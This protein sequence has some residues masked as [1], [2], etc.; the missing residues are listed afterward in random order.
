MPLRSSGTQATESLRLTAE[1]ENGRL[2]LELAGRFHDR[3]AGFRKRTDAER[4]DAEQLELVCAAL[5]TGT[6]RARG[7]SRWSWQETEEWPQ[8]PEPGARRLWFLPGRSDFTALGPRADVLIKALMVEL[9]WAMEQLHVEA[10]D[11]PALGRALVLLDQALV[12][13]GL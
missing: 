10:A 6:D 11:R 1:F 12:R 7:G 4:L 13:C 9:S 5:A 2:R 8:P 3:E